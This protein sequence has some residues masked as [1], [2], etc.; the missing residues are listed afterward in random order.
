[1]C[2]RYTV[3]LSVDELAEAFDAPAAP[4]LDL[5]LP[6]WN[7]A[8]TQDAPALV[9]GPEGRRLGGLRWGLVPFWADDP[10]MGNRLI[11]ARSETAHEKPAFRAAFRR[12][13]CLL[14]ADGFYEWQ[15]PEDS[16][17]KTPWWIHGAAGAPLT[18]AGLWERWE[19]P[20]D[21]EELL[22][23]TILTT[24]ASPWM[25]SIHGRMPV[26]VPPE[27]RDTWMATEASVDDLRELLEPAPD[28]ALTGHPVST[29]VN[30]PSN[31]GPEL[32]E[33]V[34]D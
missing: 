31:D 21:E 26:I 14:P 16:G 22:T 6:R 9:R 1:M 27:S 7:V 24:R 8:P 25:E 20:D 23:F 17:P 11:N 4:D 3:G 5:G 28:H 19:D 15:R 18:F 12:R 33:P 34:E 10:S 30:S 29:R 13:R 32:V 2:G